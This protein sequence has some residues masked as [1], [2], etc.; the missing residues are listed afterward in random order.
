MALCARKTCTANSAGFMIVVHVARARATGRFRNP[1]LTAGLSEGAVIGIA[2]GAA[3]FLLLLIIG[4]IF[5]LYIVTRSHK[6]HNPEKGR[7]YHW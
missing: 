1:C 5:F 3:V 2:V 7:P 4:V 6:T